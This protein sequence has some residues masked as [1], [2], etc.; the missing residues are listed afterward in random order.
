MR[1]VLGFVLLTAACAAPKE[2]TRGAVVMK[3]A[4]NEAHIRLGRSQ[5]APGDKVRISREL[6]VGAG[7]G[8]QCRLEDVG[9][10]QV[11]DV[12]DDTY[13]LARF[14]STVAYKEGDVV[15]LVGR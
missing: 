1:F 9:E 6:C 14:P 11:V 2:S 12:I 10:G 8:K 4:G 3:V 7:R 13:S 15:E 5:V